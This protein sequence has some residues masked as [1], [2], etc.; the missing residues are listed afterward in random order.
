MKIKSFTK[1]A[2]L[3][4]LF[5]LLINNVNAAYLKNIPMSLQ[6]PDGTSINAFATGDEYY[7]RI[8]DAQ[9]YTITIN[10]Q[11]GFYVYALLQDDVLVPSAYIVGQANPQLTEIQPGACIS[12][13]KW[14]QLR[15]DFWENTPAKTVPGNQNLVPMSAGTINNI[16]VYI[17]F[18][19]QTE[20]TNNVSYFDG[21]FNNTSPTA[22]SM[23]NYFKEV[24]FNTLFINSSYYPSPAGSLIVSYQDTHERNYYAPF[25]TVTNPIGYHDNERTSREHALLA[26]AI[27]AIAS[28]VPAGLNIDYDNDNYV[29][30]ICFVIKGGTTDWS[31]L[32]WPHRWALFSESVYINSKRVWDYNLQLDDFLSGSGNGV[33]SH[34][35]FHTLGAPDLYHYSGD[36]NSPVGSWDIMEANANPPQSMGAYMKYQYGNW[37]SSIPTITSSGTYTLNPVTSSTNNCYKI[38]SPNSTTEFFVLEYRKKTG[39]FENSLPGSGLLVYRINTTVGAGNAGGPPDEVYLFRPGGSP[40]SNGTVSQANFSSETG[41]IE[42]NNTTNPYAFFSDGSLANIDI[43]NVTS[44][45][46]NTISFTVTVGTATNFTA[47]K[48]TT[49][50]ATTVIFTDQTIGL[51]SSWSW[52]FTPATVS[53]VDGT[54]ATSQNPHVIFNGTGQ[55]SVSLTA[56]GPG[57][58]N[59]KTKSNFITIL[60]TQTLPF[61][62]NFESNSFAT[63]NWS[64]NNPDNAVTW[65]LKTVGGNAPGTKAAYMNFY[66]YGS[67]GQEDMLISPPVNLTSNTN[68]ILTFKVAYRQ[69][70]NTYHDTLKVLIYTDCGET[71]HSIPYVKTG[72]A[73]ATGAATTNSFTPSVASDWRTDTI[74][75]AGISGNVIFKFLTINDYGNNLYIDDVNLLQAGSMI[76]GTVSYFN[77]G[78]T[79]LDSTIVSLKQGN[80]TVQQTTVNGAGVYTFSNVSNGSYTLSATST[81]KWGGVNATDALLIMKHFVGMTLLTGLK[82]KAGNCDLNPII[83][84]VD[85]LMAQKRGINVISSFPA[86]N[87]TFTTPSVNVPV[88]GVYTQNISG[89][90]VADVNGSYVPY[91]K[92]EPSVQLVQ[93]GN[94]TINGSDIFVLPVY[95]EKTFQ[96]GAVSLLLNFNQDVEVVNLTSPLL[97]GNKLLWHQENQVLYISWCDLEPVTFLQGDIFLEL[98][99]KTKD[100]SKDLPDFEILSMP[101]S[102][103]ADKDASIL[104]DISLTYP[105]VMTSGLAGFECLSFPNPF[106]NQVSIRF[107][108]P[109]DGNVEISVYSSEGRKI[110]SLY[111]KFTLAGELNITWNGKDEGNTDLPSGIY[112]FRIT[113]NDKNLIQKISRLKE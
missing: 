10:R 104:P 72:T 73:L 4:L 68:A 107:K 52:S 99:L 21:M 27:N 19:D 60:S 59:T 109:E 106:S 42:I 44:S 85:A 23:Y 41:R 71:L 6:Q 17:R 66:D 102:E 37:I 82:Q 110:T 87:W 25:D 1:T 69:Y 50:P 63:L 20:F 101:V 11:T 96:T 83:N 78:I 58:S 64:I 97:S 47:N 13:Q 31:T 18:S 57:G 76:S 16:V 103:I 113:Q 98:S 79:H 49:C 9:N 90:C 62:D 80:T 40:S 111:H 12:P 8:H 65:A 45:A 94:R 15:N 34:E 35:M 86:G 56:S 61:I 2:F 26:S 84:S 89:L 55:Y 54:S 32:L 28:Q 5:A 22:N 48:T 43:S 75:L 105:K 74:S 38:Y 53:Y 70:D 77:A 100:H 14:L 67:Q 92:S 95:A 91:T 7:Y 39:T 30:N 46:G 88:P 93:K 112:Y 33:L 29:D 81:K 36:G 51:P 108:T 24:S 3:I